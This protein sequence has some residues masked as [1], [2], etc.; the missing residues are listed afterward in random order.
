MFLW[1]AKGKSDIGHL[2][3]VESNPAPD[4]EWGYSCDYKTLYSFKNS[5]NIKDL[6]GDS[7]FDKWSPLRINL[8]GKAFRIQENYW[9]RLNQIAIRSARQL[10]GMAREL[11]DLAGH[12]KLEAA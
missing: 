3:Q 5:V 8:Q 9:R 11:Q 4:H 6:R 2:L 1:R 12:F 10:A 7:Y